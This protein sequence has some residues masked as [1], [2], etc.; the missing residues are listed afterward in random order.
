MLARVSHIQ[1]KPERI[2]TAMPVLQDGTD[3]V[4]QLPGFEGGYL[5]VNRDTGEI[6][7]I[8]L[9]KSEA[10]VHGSGDLAVDILQQAGTKAGATD[11]AE[12]ETYEVL[13]EV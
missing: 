5:L 10:H 11:P 12:V 8:T 2:E 13:L 1:G 3:R 6:V 4:Q 7:T 9:W